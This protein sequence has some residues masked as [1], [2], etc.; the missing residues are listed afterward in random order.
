MKLI[1]DKK[2]ENHQKDNNLKTQLPIDGWKHIYCSPLKSEEKLTFAEYLDAEI[3]L[4]NIA[5]WVRAILRSLLII[6]PLL[7]TGSLLLLFYK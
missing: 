5:F 4:N 6:S 2:M 1:T 3:I 7:I